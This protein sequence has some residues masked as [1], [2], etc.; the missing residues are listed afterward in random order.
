MSALVADETSQRRFTSWLMGVFAGT[1]LLL[2]MI[3]IYGVVAYSVSQ[4]RQEIGVRMALGAA[5]WDVLELVIGGGLGLAAC[6]LAIGS[7]GA[8][9]LRPS[10]SGLLYGVAPTDPATFG[11]AALALLAA[12]VLATLAPGLRATRVAPASALRDE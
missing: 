11:V 7:A 9:A 2:A 4:R 8:L 10:V 6:G 1:A 3:G 12:A 5:R